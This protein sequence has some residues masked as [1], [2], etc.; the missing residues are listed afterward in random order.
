LEGVPAPTPESDVI[1]LV[2]TRDNSPRYR[3]EKSDYIV[4]HGDEE[5]RIRIIDEKTLPRE[6]RR[7]GTYSFSSGSRFGQITYNGDPPPQ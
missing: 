3:P 2:S 7:S 1:V 4:K 5:L 6:Q